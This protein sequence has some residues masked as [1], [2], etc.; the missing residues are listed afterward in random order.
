MIPMMTLMR[1]FTKPA[2]LP[3]KE[4]PVVA[5]LAETVWRD[6][7]SDIVFLPAA[8]FSATVAPDAQN[9]SPLQDDPIV[10]IE[11]TGIQIQNAV[12]RSI[13][14]V[15]KAFGGLLSTAGMTTTVAVSP[16]G[17]AKV[18]RIDAGGKRLDPSRR[19]RVAMPKPLADG[20]LGYFQIWDKQTVRSATDLTIVG[21]FRKQTGSTPAVPSYRINGQ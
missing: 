16:D 14:Y 10:I 1:R 6:A 17:R 5:T 13:S 15:P 11:L 18:L 8:T 3:L 12:T 9:V 7:K 4:L 21:C 19:Y 20:Q 2:D